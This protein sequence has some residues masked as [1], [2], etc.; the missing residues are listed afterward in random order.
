MGY[1]TFINYLTNPLRRLSAKSLLQTLFKS[2]HDILSKT[3]CILLFFLGISF[4][5]IAQDSLT[6]NGTKI[7]YEDSLKAR[8]LLNE[9]LLPDSEFWTFAQEKPGNYSASNL[10]VNLAS[11]AY[12]VNSPKFRTAYVDSIFTYLDNLVETH[13]NE[14]VRAEFLY[15][16]LQLATQINRTKLATRYYSFLTSEHGG[17][18]Y[19]NRATEYAP[20]RAIQTGKTVPDFNLPTLKDTTQTFTNEDFSN[21][22][23]LVDIWGTWCGPC[24]KEMPY[25]HKAYKKFRNEGFTILSIALHDKYEAVKAFMENE[26]EMPWNHSFIKDNSNLEDEVVS[27]FEVFGV[28]KTFLVNKKGEIIATDVDLRGERLLNTLEDVFGIQ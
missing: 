20:D 23:Y 5:S 25:L 22:I 24:I 1:H 11:I 26:W 3:A 10:F 16:G 7:A 28:P 14:N 4:S 9:E 12:P 15:K 13:E 8:Q 21:K 17:S 18:H 19:T 27:K 6:V 2:I